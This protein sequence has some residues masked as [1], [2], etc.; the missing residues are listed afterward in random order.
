M[1]P[2]PDVPHLAPTLHQGCAR[3]AKVGE[4]GGH[5]SVQLWLL[6]IAPALGR[7]R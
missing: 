3:I 6:L 7:S 2:G 5:L 1:L 4:D